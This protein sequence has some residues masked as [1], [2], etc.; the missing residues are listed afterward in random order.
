MEIGSVAGRHSGSRIERNG[1]DL[2]IG[3]RDWLAGP[4]SLG[5]QLCVIEGR[6]ASKGEDTPGKVFAKHSHRSGRQSVSPLA[7][8][9]ELKAKENLSLS[10]AG[11]EE[12]LSGV[13]FQPPNDLE[14]GGSQVVDGC[15]LARE[16]SAPPRYSESG[17]EPGRPDARSAPPEPGPRAKCHVPLPPW[18]GSAGQPELAVFALTPRRGF[19]W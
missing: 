14:V 9:Q 7:R 18:S 15:L 6:F 10:D 4:A 17:P 13:A 16:G 12:A 19:E 3:L 2:S 1:G 5:G 11:R 8:G